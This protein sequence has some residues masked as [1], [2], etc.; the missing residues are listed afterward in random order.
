[1]RDGSDERSAPSL[2]TGEARWLGRVRAAGSLAELQEVTGTDSEHDAYLAAK[3]TWRR[4]RRRELGEPEQS[5]TDRLPGDAT[6]VD[7]Q[8]FVVHGVTHADTDAERSF[9][10]E[11][12][13]GF[14]A[15]GEEVY[16]E[17]GI[18]PM[19]FDDL[20][21]VFEIDDYRWAM[22]H[23]RNMPIDSHIDGLIEETFEEGAVTDVTSTASEFRDVVFSLIRSGSGVY[24][25]AFASA[26]GDVAS[27]FL[28]RHEHIGTAEDFA[29]FEKSRSA[30]MDPTRLAELQ[31]YYRQ[32]FLPQ[33]IEREWLRR[34]DPE[35]EL[36][37][38][39][40]N[41]RIAAHALY[42]ASGTEPVHVVTGAAHQ[43]GV[44]YYLEAYRDGEWDYGEFELVP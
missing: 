38:H 34:H 21:A 39:A 37:T 41:E 42:H 22:H 26:L 25:D 7:G 18:R 23:C 28:M 27:T 35:L 1:M 2:R 33:P 20:D 11:H 43:P 3:P 13:T 31:Q 24:G 4:L 16:C 6:V 29:A 8:E 12:V 30:A 32:V 15:S 40:R 19:Y 44:A 14:L 5:G 10:R 9:L 17:Q 36:F